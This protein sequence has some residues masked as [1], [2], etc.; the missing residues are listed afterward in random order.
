M[1]GEFRS[2]VIGFADTLPLFKKKLPERVKSKE[3]FKQEG[4]AN[5]LLPVSLVHNSNAHNAVS[6]VKILAALIDKMQVSER[7][8][9][10]SAKP[11]N[12]VIVADR[13]KRKAKTV[14]VTLR[15]LKN[16]GVSAGMITKL[17][18]AELTLTCLKEYFS[19]GTIKAV[20]AEKVTR[21][22]KSLNIIFK[23][24]EALCTGTEE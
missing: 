16:H 8:V 11:V 15:P 6:D 23:A 12:Y 9:I 13:Q 5:D 1:W 2:I 20:L 10:D 7:E 19:V 21:Q 3:T 4:L 14:E 18:N 22:A 17:A 24:V